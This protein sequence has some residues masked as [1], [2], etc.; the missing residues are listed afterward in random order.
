MS[1]PT[2]DERVAALEQRVT[3]LE[4]D[5]ANGTVKDWRRTIGMFTGNELAKRV[6][7]AILKAREEERRKARRRPTA[8]RK[9]SAKVKR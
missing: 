7:A 5:V 9:T 1:Q 8:R 3:K 2:L 4:G 6:D